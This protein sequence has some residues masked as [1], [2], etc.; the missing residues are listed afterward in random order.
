Y[1]PVDV[2]LAYEH[3]RFIAPATTQTYALSLHERSSDLRRHD[4][5]PRASRQD[6]NQD[7]FPKIDFERAAGYRENFVRHRCESR[8]RDCPHRSEEHTSELQSRENL[9]CRLLLE[10]KKGSVPPPS[11]TT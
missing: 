10:K 8:D 5:K 1:C 4:K 6:R 11:T 9:V 7:K 2:V 3:L